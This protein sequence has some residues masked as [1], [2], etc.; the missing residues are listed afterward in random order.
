MTTPQT[1]EI[2][3]SWIV[4]RD[5]GPAPATLR[6]SVER[7]T[8][9]IGPAPQER[10]RWRFSLAVAAAVVVALGGIALIAYLDAGRSKVA[11]P[12]SPVA[13]P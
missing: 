9:D 11:S 1:D 12:P 4:T 5:P 10:R 7:A 6:A 2:L 8:R 3:R 13:S